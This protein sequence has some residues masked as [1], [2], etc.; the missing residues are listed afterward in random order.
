MYVACKAA[1]A[2]AGRTR[3]A[4]LVTTKYWRRIAKERAGWAP[5]RKRRGV[6]FGGLSGEKKKGP[7]KEFL[8]TRHVES[9]VPW[10]RT[11]VSQTVPGKVKFHVRRRR[12]F[13][14]VYFNRYRVEENQSRQ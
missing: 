12:V 8:L 1:R 10:K 13:C 14:F 6:T 3:A 9:V 11:S 2:C 4:K 7:R 5:R